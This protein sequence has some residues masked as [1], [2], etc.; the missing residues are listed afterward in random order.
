MKKHHE[1][2]GNRP[3]SLSAQDRASVRG[4]QDGVIHAQI[5]VGGGIGAHDNGVINSN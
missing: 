3:Q 2:R 4:G 1:K 5:T